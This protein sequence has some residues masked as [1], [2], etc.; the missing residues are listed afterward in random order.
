[1]AGGG[2]FFVFFKT[3]NVPKFLGKNVESLGNPEKFDGKDHQTVKNIFRTVVKKIGVPN[4]FMQKN[5]I[6]MESEKKTKKKKLRN[7][8]HPGPG[9][10]ELIISF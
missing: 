1:M 6:L 8:A 4:V 7:F 9:F 3:G 10:Q 2:F 5:R